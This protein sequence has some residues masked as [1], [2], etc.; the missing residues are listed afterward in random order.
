MKKL[1]QEFIDEGEDERELV[2]QI[3]GKDKV[4]LLDMRNLDEKSEY[5]RKSMSFSGKYDDEV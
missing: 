1:A 2:H 4:E 5:R 3:W